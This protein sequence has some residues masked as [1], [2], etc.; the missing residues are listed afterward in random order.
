M[1]N[2]KLLPALVSILQTRNLTASAAALNVTQSAMSKTLAQIREAFHDKILI[3]EGNQFVLTH[4]GEQL[5]AQLPELMHT[6]D[7]LYAPNTMEL[8]FCQ[9]RFSIASSDYVAQA[10]LP[11]ITREMHDKAPNVSLEFQAWQPSKLT[12]LADTQID[13]VTTIAEEVPENLQGRW[14]AEDKLVVMLRQD[15]PI[16]NKQQAFSLDDYCQSKHILI[17]GGGDKNS[18]LD[19][20]LLAQGLQRQVLIQVPFYQAAIELVLNTDALLTLPMHIAGDFAQRHDVTLRRLPISLA[21]NQYYLLWHT[22]HHHDPEH[23]WF[24]E[25]CTGLLQKHLIQTIKDGVKF[26]HASKY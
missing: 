24:R 15:H 11:M 3:R 5:K 9:R 6:L 26:I 2:Y 17:S 14:F 18:P 10:V 1:N 8:E 23:K 4:R 25:L 21:A 19:Q 16:L 13:L 22:K 7:E 20:A 12:E